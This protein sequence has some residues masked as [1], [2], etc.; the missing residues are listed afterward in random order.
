MQIVHHA[1]A[2]HPVND[3]N[4]VTRDGGI[5]SGNSFLTI[6]PVVL[7]GVNGTYSTFTSTFRRRSPPTG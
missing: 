5:K 4:A 3:P 2:N 1:D 7:G 6:R